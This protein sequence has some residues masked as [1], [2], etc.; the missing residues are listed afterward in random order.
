M[1]REEELATLRPMA[2]LQVQGY[3][4]G[5]PMPEADLLALL[6]GNP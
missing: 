1:E 4:L 6:A 3:L 2:P 5:R